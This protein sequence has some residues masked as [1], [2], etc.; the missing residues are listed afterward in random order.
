[1]NAK[2]LL[3]ALLAVPLI[4][5]SN[6]APPAARETSDGEILAACMNGQR[7]GIDAHQVMTCSIAR[8]MR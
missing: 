1:M 4:G 3:L 8:R 6:A 7:I 5:L 2:S